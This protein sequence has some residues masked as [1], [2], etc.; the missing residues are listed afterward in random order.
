MSGWVKGYLLERCGVLLI[1]GASPVV[2]GRPPTRP[3]YLARH[4]PPRSKFELPLS[5]PCIVSAPLTTHRVSPASRYTR[6]RH[7]LPC[8]RNTRVTPCRR[9]F[10]SRAADGFAAHIGVI[11]CL[12]LVF[13]SLTPSADRLRTYRES[14][15]SGRPDHETGGLG[16]QQVPGAGPVRPCLSVCTLHF[17]PDPLAASLLPPFFSVRSSLPL[18]CASACPVELTRPQF[19]VGNLLPIILASTGLLDSTYFLVCHGCPPRTE[20]YSTGPGTPPGAWFFWLFRDACHRFRSSI[21]WAASDFRGR[22]S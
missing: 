15:S 19:D 9:L 18:R 6:D 5:T 10:Q 13:F 21:S 14:T 4:P 20:S 3:P 11:R 12:L 16:R 17:G 2:E 22:P 7:A 1:K 8:C